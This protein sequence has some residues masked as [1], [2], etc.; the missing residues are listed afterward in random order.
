[1]TTYVAQK[2][3]AWG[4]WTK[5]TEMSALAK[6][7]AFQNTAAQVIKW[8]FIPGV[9]CLAAYREEVPLHAFVSP[10]PE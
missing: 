6:Y 8:T 5:E 9:I 4:W 10:L 7:D 2:I 3:T 1:M